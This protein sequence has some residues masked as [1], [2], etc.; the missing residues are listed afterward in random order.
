MGCCASAPSAGRPAAA[1]QTAPPPASLLSIVVSTSSFRSARSSFRSASTAGESEVRLPRLCARFAPALTHIRA[2]A[3]SLLTDSAMSPPPRERPSQRASG[4]PSCPADC[5]DPI[6]QRMRAPP[7]RPSAANWSAEARSRTMRRP[8]TVERSQLAPCCEGSCAHGKGRSPPPRTCSSGR[9][10]GG[11]A[12][13]TAGSI[14]SSAGLTFPRR[15]AC[16]SCTLRAISGRASRAVRCIASV[17]AAWTSRRWPR[18]APLTGWCFITCSSTSFSCGT[19]C[20]SC[21]RVCPRRSDGRSR[22]RRP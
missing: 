7:S 16:A 12:S 8:G 1:G 2:L 3:A 9:S 20:R 5:G 19:I 4:A 6:S 13:A 14:P 11:E 10:S 17:W 15:R 18:C 22:A 21:R